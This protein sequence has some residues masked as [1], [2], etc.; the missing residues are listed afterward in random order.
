MR[1]IFTGR[2]RSCKPC[3]PR[4]QLGTVTLARPSVRTINRSASGFPNALVFLLRTRGAQLTH[5]LA[6]V[7][8]LSV[9]LSVRLSH[10]DIV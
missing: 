2:Q 1:P 10:A 5:E 6:I 9:R 3:I 4:F 8:M 7:G